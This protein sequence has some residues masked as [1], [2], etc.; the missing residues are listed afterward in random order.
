MADNEKHHRWI[1]IAAG[2]LVFAMLGTPALAQY[3]YGPPV[4]PHRAIVEVLRD[5][6]FRRISAPVLNRDVYFLDAVD[7]DGEPVRLIVDAFSGDIIKAHLRQRAAIHSSRPGWDEWD[8]LLPVPRSAQPPRKQATAP[9]PPPRDP[10][11]TPPAVRQPAARPLTTKKPTEPPKP[12]VAV[13]P[14]G[15]KAAPRVIPIT[16]TEPAV[17][18]VSPLDD[19]PARTAP[20]TPFVPPA[21]LE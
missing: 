16:P 8:E 7:P 6:G 19:I 2:G 14:Q 15:S 1:S 5:E 12:P 20:A 4:L 3:Y 17:P 18:P 13:V 11:S 9:T 21:P 10:A